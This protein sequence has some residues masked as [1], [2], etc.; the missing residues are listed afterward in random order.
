MCSNYITLHF[1][2]S[3]T[4]K[5][6][7]KSAVLRFSLSKTSDKCKNNTMIDR[8]STSK[9][10]E[11]LHSTLK[12]NSWNSH[13]LVLMEI[14]SLE[15]NSVI[16]NKDKRELVIRWNVRTVIDF[17]PPNSNLWENLVTTSVENLHKKR[18]RNV[19]LFTKNQTS[20][21]E[22]LI[23]KINIIVWENGRGG[24]CMSIVDLSWDLWRI[25][26]LFYYPCAGI[27]Q[28]FLLDRY[29]VCFGVLMIIR[30]CLVV[31]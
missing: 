5:M 27:L 9:N 1:W 30:F 28:N 3:N 14:T 11:W 29:C 21:L 4:A 17:S 24:G 12:R 6:H 20:V 31:G 18:K 23:T 10:V 16:Y 25:E 7:N 19:I 26:I 13:V 22:R 15:T 8:S 2:M